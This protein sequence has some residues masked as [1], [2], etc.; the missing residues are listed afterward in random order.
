MS[1]GV[2]YSQGAVNTES[3]S[4]AHSLPCVTSVMSVFCVHLVI[5]QQQLQLEL[6][7]ARTAEQPIGS[8]GGTL[9]LSDSSVR[10][11]FGQKFLEEF[12]IWSII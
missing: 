9:N 10:W 2:P 1:M 8:A 7:E 3:R 12:R 6:P 5:Y 4:Q 11:F